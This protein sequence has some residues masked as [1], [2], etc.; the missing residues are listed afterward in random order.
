VKIAAVEGWVETPLRR[1]VS[2]QSLNS[3]LMFIG[4]S[5]FRMWATGLLAK[6]LR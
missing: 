3:P 2:F 4:L 1:Y 6:V 5:S